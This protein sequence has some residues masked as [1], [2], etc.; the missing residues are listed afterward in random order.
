MQYVFALCRKY[1]FSSQRFMSFDRPGTCL[2]CRKDEP[3]RVNTQ[4]STENSVK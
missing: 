3:G 1:F 2:T 4:T